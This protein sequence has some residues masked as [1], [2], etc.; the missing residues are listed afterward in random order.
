[1]IVPQLPTCL[2]KQTFNM[3]VYF[4]HRSVLEEYVNKS[5]VYCLHDF[6]IK[7]FNFIH[8]LRITIQII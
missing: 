4:D 3:F 7:L 8:S 2:T 5:T 6:V 1:M